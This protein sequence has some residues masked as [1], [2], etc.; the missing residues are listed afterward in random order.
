[1]GRP[2][3]A[4]DSSTA[5][6]IAELLTGGGVARDGEAAAAA[7]A[8]AAVV[9]AAKVVTR[10]ALVRGSYVVRQKQELQLQHE[11]TQFSS[12]SQF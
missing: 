3:G 12:K 8:V 6:E 10:A 1:M 5:A 7:A 11:L 4:A 2:S 9:E